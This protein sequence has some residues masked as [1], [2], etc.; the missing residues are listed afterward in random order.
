MIKCS[1]CQQEMDCITWKHLSKHNITLKE[2]KNA[3][4][5]S[6]LRSEAATLR[7]Q[8][9]AT[10]A[11]ANRVGVP[12]SN[13]TKRRI[14]Q[15]KLDNPRSAWNKGIPMTD[16]QK[17]KLSTTRKQMFESG[18]LTHWN[19]GKKLS[20][21]T[22]DRI[23]NT[24]LQ[25]ERTFSETSKN[26]RKETY[27]AKTDSGWVHHNTL[28]LQDKL[29]PCVYAKLDSK[30]W[31]YEQHVVNR[32]TIASICCE[33]GLHW[34]N[35]NKTVSQY[36][37]K[38]GIEIQY[39]HQASS[40]QQVDLEKFLTQ[41]G[42]EIITRDR[43]LI[44]PYELDIVI[45]SKN[46]AIEYCGLYWHS[47]EYKDVEYHRTKY[48]M[49]KKIGITLLTIYSDEWLNTPDIVKSMLMH[50]LDMAID[51]GVGARQCNIQ[52]VSVADR[53]T[54]LNQYHIQGNGSGSVTY[55]LYLDDVLVACMAFS[56]QSVEGR[57]LLNRYATSRN[58][59]G[60][61]SRLL[62]YFIRT[63]NA[64]EIVSFSDNR[65]SDGDVYRNMGFTQVAVIPPDYEY[66]IGET[67]SHKFNFRHKYL[68]Y[69]LATYDPNKSEIENTN[70]AG[71]HRI[72]DCGKK[73]WV[74]TVHPG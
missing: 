29:T 63:H 32:R 8:Q 49:C 62:K 57:W 50:K 37:V 60:G 43:T 39:Y 56:K 38:H 2:Y 66:V 36:L 45:P 70:S 41:S 10:R 15:T 53:T 19:T 59:R 65:W 44:K 5:S 14:Q 11:N 35:S 30:D 23:S 47:T 64:T 12:R 31:L 54:F 74:L 72:Y 18:M 24:A 51:R 6:P 28:K 52:L 55:G 16:D 7:K 27:N 1:I 67:R 22:K 48:D 4:P 71:V 9:A 13:E 68:P 46:I 21:V 26:K 40:N 42:V 34:K 69:R 25:Q 33:L 3:Y 17:Q 58:V 61:F 73:K 20:D